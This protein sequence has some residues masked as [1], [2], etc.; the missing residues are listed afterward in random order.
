MFACFSLQSLYSRTDMMM[1]MM[2]KNSPLGA[3][4]IIL[5]NLHL[6]HHTEMREELSHLGLTELHEHKHTI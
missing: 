4:K 3:S 1:M 2:M 5:D 6:C